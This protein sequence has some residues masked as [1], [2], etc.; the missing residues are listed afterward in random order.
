MLC[1]VLLI[2]GLL[3]PAVASAAEAPFD[4]APGDAMAAEYFRLET[5]H[6]TQET[7]ERVPD[8]KDPKVR[9]E[10]RRQLRDML[11]IDPLPERTPLQP[12]ITGTV[13][14]PQFTVEKLHFQSSP[15]LY[16]TG[17]LYVPKNLTGK[18]PAIL[19]VCGH[20]LQKKDGVSFGNKAGYQH[21]G[22][23][24]ARN[25]YVCLTI[26]TLQLGEI[27]GTHHGLHR[28]NRWWWLARGYTPAGVEAWNCIRALDYL[29]TRPEVDAKK[30]GVTGRSGGGAYSWWILGVDDRIQAAVP[31]AGITSLQNHV[32]DGVITG[33]CDCMFQCNTYRWDYSMIPGL[34]APKPLLIS[35]TD[36]D[37][38]FPLDGVVD[39]YMKTRGVYA[40]L[41][42][43]SKLGLQI[44]EGPHK[45][46][47]EL[48]IHAFVWM[49]RHLK[50]E[51]R[52]IEQPA[53][54][55]F[56]PSQLRVFDELP[57]DEINTRIDELFVPMAA[58]PPL[59]TSKEEWTSL[60]TRLRDGLDEKV[61]RGWPDHEPSVAELEVRRV[62]EFADAGRK[63][64]KYELS[65]QQPYRLPLWVVSNAAAKADGAV[66]LVP[67]DA[68]AWPVFERW[69][70]GVFPEAGLPREG[71]NGDDGA[72][73]WQKL[74]ESPGATL[75]FTAP[76][77]IGPTEWTREKVPR[78]HL[79]R[80]FA[81]LGQTEDG[82]RTWDVRCALR[83]TRSLAELQNRAVELLG[84][85]DAAVWTLYASLYEP[86]AA[87]VTLA[88]LPATHAEGPALL[89]VLRVLDV[90]AA[91]TLAAAHAPVVVEHNG[92][93]GKGIA[94][95]ARQ[96]AAKLKGDV[97]RLQIQ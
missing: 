5:A 47:Q 58:T 80:R 1:R 70:G 7:A 72:E 21:H 32:V 59:P 30:L 14:H 71:G 67:V 27:Q 85:G 88:G 95:Y 20:S 17:N 94:E 96:T 91:V 19:Y 68:A 16:V 34:F 90:P 42:A 23:W 62:G 65:S 22:A 43:E 26:D 3:S 29:E 92:E 6:L 93:G 28:E 36:K 38:I 39:V 64:E 66:T 24:F 50:G 60:A 76:R 46:T 37:K 41:N 53:V 31:V 51:E 74:L 73:R 81:L 40:A 55:F 77:G 87:R 52:P 13:D 84:E 89:N 57:K 78:T 56:D 49:N 61:F 69:L 86:P 45:D 15:G 25:G 9:E 83:A 82:M 12:V 75:V 33:H 44:T 63:L 97:I 79:R 35:N 11:G 54:K 10:R 8:L 4:S 2:L 48:H 18:V